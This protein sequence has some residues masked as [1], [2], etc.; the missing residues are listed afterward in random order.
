[1]TPSAEPDHIPSRTFFFGRHWPEGFDFPS[2]VRCNRITRHDEQIVAM[3]SRCYPEAKTQQEVDELLKAIHAVARNY[4]D[5][6]E[7][8]KPTVRQ[9]RNADKKYSLKQDGQ[10][11]ADIPAVSVSG[12]LVNSAIE[13][14]SRKLFCALFYKH[15][16]SI[17]GVEGGIAVKWFSNVQVEHDEIPRNLSTILNGYPKVER[18]KMNLDEQFFYRY[19]IPDSKEIAAFL[20]VFR[21][22]FAIVGYV[23]RNAKNFGSPMNERILRPIGVQAD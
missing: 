11:Y 6:I 22:S 8:M 18:S 3:L 5:V 4:P 7:E 14:F 10:S 17:L 20:A 16:G 21:R 9:L 15:T 19:A 1:M 12:P 13:N 2:C 23:N